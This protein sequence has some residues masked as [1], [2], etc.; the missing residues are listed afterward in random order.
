MRR[1]ADEE[2]WPWH[3][4]FAQAAGA[5]AIVHPVNDVGA[6]RWNAAFAYLDPRS[7]ARRT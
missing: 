1:F 7:R 2:L 4:A 6:V 5:D 3:R